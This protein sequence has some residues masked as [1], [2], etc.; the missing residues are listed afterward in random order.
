LQL[1]I[2]FYGV[3]AAGNLLLLVPRP[4][5]SQVTDATGKVWQVSNIAAACVFGTIFTMGAFT[6]LAWTRLKSGGRM[7]AS[8]ARDPTAARHL[9]TR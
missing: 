6:V 4:G 2:L 5:L 8:D 7:L 9:A 1:A 3:S